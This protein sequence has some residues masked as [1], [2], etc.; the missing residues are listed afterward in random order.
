MQ[1]TRTY[2]AAVNGIDAKLVEIEVSQYASP[3]S[4]QDSSISIVGLPD[5][6]IK[7]AKERIRAAFFNSG[8]Y[9]PDTAITIN[10]A[11]ADTKK[12]GSSY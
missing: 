3:S 7:E 9:F 5:A 6:A 12:E 11:P 2:S 4:S 10:L 1:I 8:Y